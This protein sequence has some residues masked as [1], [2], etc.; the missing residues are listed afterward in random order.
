MNVIVVD[1]VSNKSERWHNEA[2]NV[3]SLINAD[4]VKLEEK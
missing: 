2:A 1:G 3:V 4:D